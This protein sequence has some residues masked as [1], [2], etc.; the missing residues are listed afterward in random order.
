MRIL[1]LFCFSFI[2]L[3]CVGKVTEFQPNTVFEMG[4]EAPDFEEIEWI[5]NEII[6]QRND[7]TTELNLEDLRGKVVLLNFWSYDCYFCRKVIR[8]L[9]VW[10]EEYRDQGL[11]VV[12]IHSPEFAYERKRSNVEEHVEE[13][14]IEYLVGLDND[15]KTWSAYHNKYRPAIYLIDREGKLQFLR[16]GTGY[17]DETELKIQELLSP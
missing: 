1:F 16:Y 12:G 13:F 4:D 3:G 17:K 11:V 7:R 5:K 8:W 14:E 15:R 6:E 2:L 10:D 9:Q